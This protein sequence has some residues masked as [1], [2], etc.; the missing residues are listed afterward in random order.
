[1]TYFGHAASL[2]ALLTGI[3]CCCSAVVGTLSG[4]EKHLSIIINGSYVHKLTFYFT[5]KKTSMGQIYLNF[6]A[7]L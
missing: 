6:S 3:K 1:M 7:K 5:S 2:A 4:S